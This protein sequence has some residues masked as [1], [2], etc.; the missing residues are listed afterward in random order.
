MAALG[1]RCPRR[2]AILV[3]LVT[4]A[5]CTLGSGCGG[6]DAATSPTATG[7]S[8][9]TPVKSTAS[10]LRRRK[11]A[12][13]RRRHRRHSHRR[14]AARHRPTV[15]AVDLPNRALT[16]G[17]ALAVGTARICRSGYA[18]SVRD[19]PESEKEEVYARYG[20]AHVPYRHEVDHLVSL[21]LGGSN[22]IS[23]LWPEPYA[24]RW[25]ARTK[26]V[27]ENRL[28]DLVCAGVLRLRS[29]QRIEARNWVAA[30]RRYVGSPPAAPTSALGS[31]GGGQ[32]GGSGA[33]TCTPGYAPCLPYKNGEDYDCYGG[34][35]NGPLF[36]R[37]GVTYTVTG[38]DP[39]RLDGNGDGRAC[40]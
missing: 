34:E 7:G 14:A 24:G 31:S 5:V 27:L 35:G 21:E 18:S 23:N 16:P 19:V 3:V 17:V 10:A 40:G 25:G 15:P 32:A 39:Y 13:H 9:A 37:P 1:L 8:A 6:G 26:D 36:T 28:H 11:T 20:V 30:Y 38:D 12:V 29:A 33:G 4:A 2:A 22:A